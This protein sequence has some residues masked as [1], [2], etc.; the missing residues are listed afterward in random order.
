MLITSKARR[1]AYCAYIIAVFILSTGAFLTIIAGSSD[2][3]VLKAGTPITK[4]AWIGIYFISLV[5]VFHKRDWAAQ[6]LKNNLPLV[7]LLAL[8]SLSYLWSISPGATFRAVVQLLLT[9]CVAMDFCLS[10]PLE[11]QLD[12]A[13]IAL[14]FVIA[15]SVFLQL[16][17]P[18]YVAIPMQ[19][20]P[21]ASSVGWCGVFGTKNEFGKTIVVALALFLSM[22]F[23][24]RRLSVILTASAIVLS[25]LAMATGSEL[26]DV[27]LWTVSLILPIIH[28]KPRPRMLAIISMFLIAMVVAGAAF[29]NA[30]TATQALGKDSTL[31]GRGPLWKL[32]LQYFRE[33]PMLGHG[34]EAFWAQD[35]PD[36]I[37]IGQALNWPDVPHSHNQYIEIL[38]GLGI[39]GLC[40]YF[41]LLADFLRKALRYARDL[42]R[43]DRR[44]PLLL[45]AMVTVMFTTEAGAVSRGGIVWLLFSSAVFSMTAAEE[46][47]PDA[48]SPQ[49]EETLELET[50]GA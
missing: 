29:T 7:A 33:R 10:M 35:S 15:A 19:S 37:R 40:V 27:F 32:S 50:V 49:I 6:I 38:L 3:E 28:W 45:L 25:H 20:D 24:R 31:T 23:V 17:L 26:N 8:A 12:L 9:T 44:W 39:A 34:W 46:E 42:E 13:A 48:A 43:R 5:R 14:G 2:P 1:L 47:L 41:W 21:S 22:P 4:C 16:F 36:A 18:S 30:A 11:S